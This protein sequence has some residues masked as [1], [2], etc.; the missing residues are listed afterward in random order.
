MS[1]FDDIIE[2]AQDQAIDE[3]GTTFTVAG[4]VDQTC[5]GVL[6]R[7]RD[8][9][10]PD[11]GGILPEI[12]ATLFASRNQF[13]GSVILAEDSEEI[14]AEQGGTIDTETG[15]VMPAIGQRIACDGSL[16][17]VTERHLDSTG[18]TL[19]LRSINR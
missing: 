6:D 10:R 14:E 17:A 5:V 7:T 18:V 19:F 16:F 11:V 1:A 2:E 8:A 12:D 15:Y 9:A 13:D 3:F 4:V